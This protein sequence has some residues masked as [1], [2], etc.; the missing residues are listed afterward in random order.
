MIFSGNLTD[1]CGS[2]VV[3]REIYGKPEFG[4][5]LRNAFNKFSKN[6][7]NFLKM[8]TIIFEME[9]CWMISDQV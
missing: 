6:F 7:P 1:A 2:V 4:F 8:A 3:S 5:R 9:I